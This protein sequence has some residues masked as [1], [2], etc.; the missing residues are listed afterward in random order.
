MPR[1]RHDR[2]PGDPRE[3]DDSEALPS[4]SGL[5]A[6]FLRSPRAIIGAI[7]LAIIILIAIFAPWIAPHDPHEIHEKGNAEPFDE[8]AANSPQNR[9]VGCSIR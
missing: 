5:W 3:R 9:L 6:S 1:R 4:L 8:R 2:S 7:I